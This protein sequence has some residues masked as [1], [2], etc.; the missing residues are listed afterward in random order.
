[1]SDSVAKTAAASAK[2][3]VYHL[4]EKME[5]SKVDQMGFGSAIY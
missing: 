3:M 2:L 5:F 4:A 1:M